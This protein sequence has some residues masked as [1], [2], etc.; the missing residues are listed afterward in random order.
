MASASLARRL[1]S[2]VGPDGLLARGDELF[3]YECDG[4]TLEACRPDL[5]VLPRTTEQVAAV[6]RACRH[7]GHPFVPRGAGT[8]LSGGAHPVPGS[9][10][11]ECSRMKRIFEVDAENRIA[12]VQPGVVNADLSTAVAGHGLFYAPDPSSQLACTIGGNVAE[13]SGGPHTLKY[14]S[15]TNHVLAVEVVMPDGEVVRLGSRTGMK[16]GFDLVGA[17]V[18]SEG[19]LGIVTEVTVRLSEIPEAVETLLVLFPDVVQACRAVGSVIGSGL[20]PAALEILDQ[21]TIAAV[22]D[23]VYAA[24]IPRDAGAVLIAELDGAACALPAQVQRIRE[25]SLENGASD[26]QVAADDVERAQFWKARKGAFGAMGRLAPDL[27]V[28]DAVVPRAK[29]PEVL[30]KVCEICDRHRLRLSNVFHA[31]DGNLHPNISFDRRD[32]DELARVLA[33]G[34]EILETCVAAGGV[35]TGEHGVGVEKRDFLHLVFN[36]E[37]LDAMRRLR[38]AF[39]PDLVCNPGK[40]FPT[41]RFC[42]ESDPKARGYGDVPLVPSDELTR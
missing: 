30:E 6:V 39:D 3:V 2:I 42:A 35:I 18:G 32:E 11:I 40:A 29:L 15:T 19:T 31:G 33:A 27:Y 41:T 7:E 17:F 14:G 36:E 13:N 24:G 23:S 5:V 21:R 26:V 22:E 8:G 37:D 34:S 16:S 20:V 9:V 12:V 28:H 38:A 4:L 1:R 10:I 25:I